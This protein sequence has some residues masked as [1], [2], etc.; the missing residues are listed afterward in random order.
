MSSLPLHYVRG[1]LFES[2]SPGLNINLLANQSV[3]PV[4]NLFIGLEKNNLQMHS[5]RNYKIPLLASHAIPVSQ[6][7]A[8]IGIC[9]FSLIFHVNCV[10][11]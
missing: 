11:N 4:T 9:H 5:R 10:Y 6:N 8:I 7:G 3:Y 2:F 1:G